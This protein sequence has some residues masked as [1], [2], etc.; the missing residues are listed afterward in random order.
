[1]AKRIIVVVSIMTMI[2]LVFM[3]TLSATDVKNSHN[4]DYQAV[5]DR[6]NEEYGMQMRFATE[7]EL[8]KVNFNF[9][10]ISDISIE[11]F[12]AQ[13]RRDIDADNIANEQAKKKIEQLENKKIDDSGSGSVRWK[14]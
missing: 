11:E 4:S 14:E 9:K 10:D 5:L 7:E 3:P 2:L 12:E 8:A 13:L 6:L 1:M